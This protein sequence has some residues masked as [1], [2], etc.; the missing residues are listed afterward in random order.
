MGTFLRK[1][2]VMLRVSFGSLTGINTLGGVEEA[3]EKLASL[4]CGSQS[5]YNSSAFQRGRWE[6]KKF[7]VC[8]LILQNIFF[9]LEYL[10]N[11]NI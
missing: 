11:K 3:E 7:V 2:I 1:K 9:V 5:L 8:R 4:L 10:L 6:I